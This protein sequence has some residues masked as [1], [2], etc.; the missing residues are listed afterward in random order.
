MTTE[1]KKSWKCLLCRSKEPKRDNNNT[2]IRSQPSDDTFIEPAQ[3]RDTSLNRNLSTADPNVTVR[4]RI[5][6]SSNESLILHSDDDESLTSPHGNTVHITPSRHINDEHL[7]QISL[8]KFTTLLQ[9][10]NKLIISSLQTS[11]QKEIEKALSKI[12]TEFKHNFEE[13]TI[14]QKQIKQDLV[15]LN[16]KIMTLE[17]SCRSLQS[18]NEKLQQEIRGFQING[19][20]S[21][22]QTS[23]GTKEKTIVLHGFAEYYWET[24][25]DITN[26][27][28]QI[29]YDLLNINLTD[30]IEEIE[31][32]GRKHQKRPLKIEL[33][34]KRMTK[35][36]LENSLYLRRAGFSITEYLSPEAL[37]ERR[38]MRQALQD[39]RLSGQH[40]I[41][42]NNTLIINGKQKPLSSHHQHRKSNHVISQENKSLENEPQSEAFSPHSPP[43]PFSLSAQST[44][45]ASNQNTRINRPFRY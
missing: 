44:N 18:E 45:K 19:S 24:N 29:F 41:I 34:S 10:N 11:F 26:R 14:E 37:H 22:H 1:S 13:V 40:A 43:V 3:I 23:N 7:E 2:P 5:P 9:E 17:Q 20:H 27:V 21:S 16:T 32:I 15:A 35:Y 31:Y 28:V 38:K 39:A 8:Q 12:K 42:K 4:K 30:Y 6:T 36:I 33:L 25:E